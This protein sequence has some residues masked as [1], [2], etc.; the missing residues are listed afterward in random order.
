MAL[1]QHQDSGSGN[2]ARTGD[3]KTFSSSPIFVHHT[4]GGYLQQKIK[5]YIREFLCVAVLEVNGYE[6]PSP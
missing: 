2:F 1:D 4:Q 5:G 3:I 6:D